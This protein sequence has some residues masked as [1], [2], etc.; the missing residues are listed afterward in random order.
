MVGVSMIS[1]HAPFPAKEPPIPTGCE[2]A[3]VIEEEFLPFTGLKR[4][5]F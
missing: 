2:A 1:L 5:S 4:R 3:G